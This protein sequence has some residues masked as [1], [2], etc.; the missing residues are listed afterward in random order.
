[1]LYACPLI[2]RQA[3]GQDE[4]LFAVPGWTVAREGVPRIPYVPG[5]D[6]ASVF[7]RAD[8]ALF[9]LPP[10]YFYWQA[11]FFLV[12]PA[13]YGTA[14]L[15]FGLVLCDHGHTVTIVDRDPAR[16]AAI[17]AGRMPFVEHGAEPLLQKCLTSGHLLL[18]SDYKTLPEQ[19]VIIVTIGT[20]VDEYLDPSVRQFD[21]VIPWIREQIQLGTI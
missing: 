20:P 3:G 1:M 10:A 21:E 4:H 15:P 12:L 13:G 9:A 2:Y 17:G 7:Y 6:P 8:E 5:R 18:K 16:L 19:D 11:P 14:R